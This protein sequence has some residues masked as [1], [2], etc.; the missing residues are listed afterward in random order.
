MTPNPYRPLG[1]PIEVPHV[2]MRL[3]LYL[4]AF[5]RFR[6]RH[7]WQKTID[8][9]D[10]RVAGHVQT[11]LAYRLRLGDQVDYYCPES[12]EPE[13]DTNIRVVWEKSGLIAVYKPPNLPIHEAGRYRLNTFCNIL[14]QKVGPEWAPMHRLDRETSGIVLCADGKSLRGNVSHLFRTRDIEK[15][16]LA[17]AVGKSVEDNFD[18]AEPMGPAIGTLFRNKQAV[19][20]DGLTAFTEFRVLERAQANFTLFE[21]KPKTGRTHQIRVHAAHRSLPLVGDTKYALDETIFLEALDHGFTPRV[22]SAVHTQRLC[23]HATQVT[24]RHPLDQK[25]YTVDCHMPDDMQ[26]IWKRLSVL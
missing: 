22:E 4:G 21:V 23:L 9:G 14:A 17:I 19:R 24:L 5:F 6:S 8:Q 20:P 15:V 16:Y 2:G 12:C 7:R 3:D 18:V 11:K 25:I 1:R 26:A 10:V 13:V